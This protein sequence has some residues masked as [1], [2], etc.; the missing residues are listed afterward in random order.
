MIAW[1][2][3]GEPDAQLKTGG[4]NQ[5]SQPLE[6]GNHLVAFVTSDQRGRHPA[7]PAEF[8]LRDARSASSLDQQIP[9]NHGC[10]FNA[11]YVL[12][13]TAAR[14]RTCRTACLARKLQSEKSALARKLQSEK[15]ALAAKSAQ[16][17]PEW[18]DRDVRALILNSRLLYR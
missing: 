13:W 2:D 7:P 8:R 17:E 4:S 10:Q 3:P 14:S 9:A 16:V 6:A 18:A 11:K 15:S 12:I 1:I 5:G